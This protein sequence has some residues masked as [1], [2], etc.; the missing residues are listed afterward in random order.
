METLEVAELV[1]GI[2]TKT[3]TNTTTTN[4]D[5]ITAAKTILLLLSEEGSF[6]PIFYTTH[7][8]LFNYIY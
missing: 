7:L 6:K 1:D 8:K 4:T 3:H 2:N 5:N